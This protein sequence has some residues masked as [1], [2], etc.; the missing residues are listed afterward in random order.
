MEPKVI[1]DPT[2]ALRLQ[3]D[4]FSALGTAGLSNNLHRLFSD[5]G[6]Y[7]MI[8]LMFIG[9]VGTLTLFNVI[10]FNN[11]KILRKYPDDDIT[12]G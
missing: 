2:K 5:A 9:R 12:I 4:V 3:L 8:S 1:T 6:L 7:V 10:V 11:K